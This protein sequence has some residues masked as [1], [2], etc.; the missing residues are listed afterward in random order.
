MVGQ[1]ISV[2]HAL[3][4]V[5]AFKG[6]I[7]GDLFGE[8]RYFAD[9][10]SFPAEQNAAVEA[11]K[12]ADLDTG[13]SDVQIVPASEAFHQWEFE[14]PTSARAGAF[15]SSSGPMARP[16]SMKVYQPQGSGPRATP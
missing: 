16:S 6:A 7:L 9:A 8:D 2:R 4:D 5:A 3:F 11:C 15:I 1:A 10:D 13:W 12:S 14:R